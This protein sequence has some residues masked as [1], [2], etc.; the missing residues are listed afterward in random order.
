MKRLIEYFIKYPVSGNVIIFLILALGYFGF[1]SLKSTTMP[2]TDPGSIIVTAQYPGASP[3]EIEQGIILKIE[4]NLRGVSGIKKISSTSQENFGRVTVEVISG[5]NTDLVLQDVRNAVDAINSFP[6][7]MEPANVSKW[8]FR[9]RAIDFMISGSVDL[10]ILKNK[11][12]LIEDDLRQMPGISKL[13][14]SGFPE[15][16][17]EIAFRE[18][19]LRAYNITFNEAA[20]AIRTANIDLTGGTIRGENEELFIRT[21]QKQFYAND[22]KDIILRTSNKGAIVRLGDV[23]NVRDKWSED[24][25]RVFVDGKPAV[26]ISVQYT[27][28]EDIIQIT[29]SVKEYLN[30]F[31]AQNDVIQTTIINDESV[32]VKTMQRILLNNGMLG[33]LFVMIF[34]TIFLN[35]SLSFWVAISIPLSFMGMFF[36]ASIYGLT[37][38]R[39]SLFGMILVIGILVDDGIVIGEN[40][41]QHYEKGK[42]P[43]RAAID[44]T[45]EV[46]PAVFAAVLTTIIAFTSML[47]VEG[48]FGQLF[49]EMAFVVIATLAIS[50]VEGALILPAHIAHSKHMAKNSKKSRLEIYMKKLTMN[51]RDKYYK[52]ILRGAINNKLLTLTIVTGL[53]FI[54]IGALNGG[55]IK[56]GSGG[57]RNVNYANVSV[58]IPPGTPEKIT[59]EVLDRIEI[60]AKKVGDRFSKKDGKNVVTSIVKS[61]TSSSTGSI[62]VNL[63]NTKERSFISTEFSNALR[64]EVGQV[65]EALRVNYVEQSHFGKPVSVALLSNNFEELNGA[66]T[67]LKY[68]LELLSELKNVIDNNQVGMRE[69]KVVLKDKAFLLGLNL[70]EVMNQVR[71]GFF[72]AEVQRINRGLD[73]VRIWVR[74]EKEDR[75]TIGNLED[76]RIRTANGLSV[77]LNEI[78]VLTFE[79]NLTSIN[80]LNGRRAITVEADAM[81]K[82]VNIADIKSELETVIL[83][84]IKSKYPSI[85]YYFGGRQERMTELMGSLKIIFPVILVLL[86][87][88][89]S[90]TF[91]SF[92]QALLIFGMVPL[93]FIGLGWG[94]AIHGVAID[95]PSYFGILALLGIIVNDS[96]VLINTLNRYLRDEE[97]FMDAIIHAGSS[98]FRPI[99]LTSL[100]TMA[101]L[102]PLIIANDPD[103]QHIVPMAISVAYGVIV[104]TFLTLLV[105]PVLLV[106][107][108]SIKRRI[109]KFKTGNMPSRESVE[110]AVL[111]LNVNTLI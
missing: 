105:L 16:E 61:I 21:K 79:R 64:K 70:Q 86:F 40:I 46:I 71:S 9:S 102:F 110:R 33:F 93:G 62:N 74:Y 23:A 27:A 15:E 76:M 89:I 50:L 56:M 51:F 6:T 78:A 80:H 58:E 52:P 91:R 37:L 17:I 5:Y 3:E 38:N 104:A 106:I 47:L 7:G 92:L 10:K 45:L 1:I 44:G 53:F 67:D 25:N 82:S 43:V 22:L 55:V 65:P 34:L 26:L 13:T 57:F 107:V 18:S 94:H 28:S 69:I 66:L 100:T 59:L 87:A 81:D 54:T 11:A 39:M 68:E 108:N 95:M 24:P 85:Q 63:I 84:K 77:P 101:G 35:R 2:Q 12:R 20:N 4:T 72:G 36:L 83:P 103:A 14:I 31:N 98:R 97:K 48:I 96:I 8:E 75:A 29:D 49:R 42:K 30:I 88:V 109:E 73:E 111:E 90:L 41:Y 60:S 32:G 99:V 19:D